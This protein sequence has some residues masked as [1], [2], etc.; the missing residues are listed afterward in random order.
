LNVLDRYGRQSID[1]DDV[2]A[3][4]AALRSGW[5]TTGPAVDR[6]E[7]GL[8]AACGVPHA[9][10]CSSGSAALL[11]AYA[12]L[13]VSPATT[14]VVPANTFAATAAAALHLGARVAIADVDPETGNLDLDA[15]ETCCA[16][17]GRSPDVVVPVHFAGAPVDG[18][19]LRALADRRGFRIVE[20]ACHALG[21]HDGEQPVGSARYA[22]AAAFSFHPVKT[23]TTAEGGSV[24]TRDP[25]LSERVRLLRTHGIVRAAERFAE[26]ELAFE[27]GPGGA[28]NP[29]YGELQE[30]GWNFRLSDLHAALG[31]SQ[32]AR[33]ERFV[34]R[35]RALAACYEAALVG[36]PLVR[37]LA[38]PARG[39]SA[40]HLYVVRIDFEAAGVTRAAVMRR[41]H[42]EGIGTQVHYVPL[43]LQ[44]LVRRLCGT[45][46]GELPGAEAYYARCLTLPLHPEMTERDVHTVVD[47]LDRALRGAAPGGHHP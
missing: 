34:A 11:L 12:A 6:F 40:W 32:L 39:R 22:D 1:E 27:G 26:A 46:P 28:P 29:W 24:T 41:L 21:A 44:P 35:R 7:A 42:D 36:H 16:A 20:D 14:V 17:S 31:C 5:L 25:E 4:V 8:A 38:F 43:H 13:G 37:P 19:R 10:S 2:E 30:L 3:V 9:V 47:A 23:I 45:G 18:P 15:L 33:L